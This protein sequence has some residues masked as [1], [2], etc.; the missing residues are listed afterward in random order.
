MGSLF[1]WKKNLVSTQTKTKAQTANT[2]IKRKIR[3][4]PAWFRRK[5]GEIRHAHTH[6]AEG[7]IVR[8]KFRALFGSKRAHSDSSCCAPI[9]TH[10]GFPS[11]DSESFPSGD[12]RKK[13]QKSQRK[14]SVYHEASKTQTHTLSQINETKAEK[15]L[16]SE[17]HRSNR[18]RRGIL[19]VV[20]FVVVHRG[21]EGAFHRAKAPREV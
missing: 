19:V 7:E 6:S 17:A 10:G 5:N 11:S 14:C 2:K 20:P 4:S 9:Q 16:S 3:G 15:K 18:R 12:H 8:G 21:M 13:N 1:G